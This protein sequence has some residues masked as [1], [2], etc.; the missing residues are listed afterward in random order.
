MRWNRKRSIFKNHRNC[1]RLGQGVRSRQ[2]P[3][4]RHWNWM[5]FLNRPPPRSSLG[6]QFLRFSKNDLSWYNRNFLLFDPRKSCGFQIFLLRS[7]KA[8]L[9]PNI[10]NFDSGDVSVRHP[11]EVIRFFWRSVYG[12]ICLI[13]WVLNLS[14][15]ST[16]FGSVSTFSNI[17]KHKPTELLVKTCDFDRIAAWYFTRHI[18]KCN[19]SRKTLNCG[20]V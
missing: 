1:L 10:I 5:H 8:Y 9:C 19:I 17:K 16:S 15:L 12:V 18:S 6:E 3:V 11:E 20:R 14:D 13:Y 2:K 7:I 4:T